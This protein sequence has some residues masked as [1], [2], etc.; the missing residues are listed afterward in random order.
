MAKGSK[1]KFKL[2]S[3]W[4]I[5]QA[6]K[7]LIISGGA[8]ARYEVELESDQS[9]FFA[10]LKNR[11]F[12]RQELPPRDQ[13]VLEE[14]ITAEIIVPTL[15]KRAKML[16]FQ[17]GD[18]LNLSLSDSKH[19]AAAKTAKAADLLVIARITST[20]AGLLKQIDYPAITQ[21]HLFVDLSFHHT[22]SIGPLVFPGETACIACLQGRLG[23]RWGDET[24]PPAPRAAGK[25]AAVARELISTELTRI[26]SGDTSLT[27]KTVSWNFQDRTVRQDQ[28][29]K[30]PVCPICTQNKIDASGALAL[31]W[32]KDESA[33]NPI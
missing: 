2:S 10:Q 14:L 19:V 8:D 1:Q 6:G 20:Y 13:R 33:S 28:L 31:P 23:T 17:T 9:S 7:S 26:S 32:V 4:A 25:Y 24:P 27:N 16:V 15:A 12:T 22:F 30:V 11:Q 3:E 5:R 18:K 29:L 21:P